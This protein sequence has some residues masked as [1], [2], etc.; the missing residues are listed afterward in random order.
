MEAFDRYVRI[1]AVIRA[2][3][4]NDGQVTSALTAEAARLGLT[5]DDLASHI[6]WDPG[7]LELSRAL[8]EIL[9][10]PLVYS[11]VSRLLID[12]NRDPE[13]PS[14]VAR[15]EVGKISDATAPKP[16]K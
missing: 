13:S 3:F 16:L 11:A 2:N 15:I 6:A 4:R 10:A 1:V 7:A 12:P 5:P 9:D 8:S 14:A